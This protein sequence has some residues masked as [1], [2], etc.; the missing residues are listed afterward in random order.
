MFI[1]LNKIKTVLKSE[2]IP[3][4][5]NL[6][7]RAIVVGVVVIIGLNINGKTIT[8]THFDQEA[9]VRCL[10]SG[11]IDNPSF[12]C[13]NDPLLGKELSS[14]SPIKK[15]WNYS[16]SS[17]EIQVVRD[18]YSKGL[19]FSISGSMFDGKRVFKMPV[20]E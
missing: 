7:V 18:G 5:Y 15:M 1:K 20:D 4:K 19:E 16:S 6:F 3:K 14:V 11:A 10:L 8:F 17:G 9:G 2:V 13:S 12:T